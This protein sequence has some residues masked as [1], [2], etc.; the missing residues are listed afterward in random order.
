M[1]CLCGVV[2]GEASKKV[3]EYHQERGNIIEQDRITKDNRH[4]LGTAW[5]QA[6]K[7]DLEDRPVLHGQQEGILKDGRRNSQ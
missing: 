1:Y 4:K 3:V 2:S 5:A 6:P 7:I